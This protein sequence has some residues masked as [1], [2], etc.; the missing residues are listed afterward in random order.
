MTDTL[1][2]EPR[3]AREHHQRLVQHVDR[4]PQL[5]ELIDQ[6]QPAQLR[7]ALDDTCTFLTDLLLPHIAASERV[8]YPQLEHVMQNRHSMAPMR[9]VHAEIR[10]CVDDLVALQRTISADQFDTREQIALRR[11]VF[12]LYALL[13]VHLAE[14]LLY[15]R[16]IEH[17]ATPEDEL[18]LATAMQHGGASDF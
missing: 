1:L 13:K 2:G 5:G 3:V 7:P 8:L 6:R 10:A 11:A 12:R 14:E 9:H 17:G 18:A 4:L 16:I 15:A